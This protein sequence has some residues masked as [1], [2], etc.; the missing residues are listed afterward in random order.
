[1]Q[2]LW[3]DINSIYLFSKSFANEKNKK[4][5]KDELKNL[6]KAKSLIEVCKKLI[7]KFDKNKERLNN[8]LKSDLEEIKLKI[9]VREEVIK[10]KNKNFLG[11]IITNDNMHAKELYNK[12]IDCPKFDI[13]DLNEL[14]EF[15]KDDLNESVLT[16][17]NLDKEIQKATMF[18]KWINKKNENDDVIM[19]IHTILT[20]YPYGKTN[21]EKEAMW[22]DFTKLK[23]GKSDLDDYLL[24]IKGNYEIE[25]ISDIESPVYTAIKEYFNKF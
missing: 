22:K 14:A 13:D 18:I 21:S 17:N 5:F 3:D 25:Q 8:I 1:M 20:D 2:F 4:K 10:I 15:L 19:T 16:E 6:D 12:Y 7:N 23:E 24:K 9:E 11:R